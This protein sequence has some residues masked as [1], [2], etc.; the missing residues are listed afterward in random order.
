MKTTPLPTAHVPVMPNKEVPLPPSWVEDLE[1]WYKF[2]AHSFL[3]FYNHLNNH[4]YHQ[5]FFPQA[6]SD[7]R[8]VQEINLQLKV[9]MLSLQ[10]R[11]QPF[12]PAT[13]ALL[14]RWAQLL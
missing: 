14:H 10:R 6:G 12:L 9:S 11:P 4:Q 2:L 5:F 13:T 1:K 7:I 3:E 8:T